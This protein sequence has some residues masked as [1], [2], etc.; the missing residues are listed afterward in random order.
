MEEAL[1]GHKKA[2]S[3][4]SINPSGREG[5]IHYDAKSCGCIKM[6]EAEEIR[7]IYG[8]FCGT[9]SR[10]LQIIS[11]LCCSTKPRGESR[12]LDTIS[13]LLTEEALNG[14]KKARSSS[15]INPSGREG[16]IHYDAKSCGCIKMFE[17][18]EIRSIYGDFCGTLS[19]SLQIISGLC[20]S[21]RR[22]Q[23]PFK[24]QWER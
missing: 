5:T 8:D 1:N 9:L 23:H 18:E 11:G 20:C 7:S 14:H 19:R 16:T 3:S 6:F 10:S 21:L 15:S 13:T 17:A 22:Q 12:S 24:E 4:S 2:R